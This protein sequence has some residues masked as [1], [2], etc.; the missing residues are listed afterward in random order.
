MQPAKIWLSRY[1]KFV[2]AFTLLLISFGGTVTTKK[3]GLS[4]PDW[5]TS[6]GHNMFT[7]PFHLW[8]GDVFWEHSHRLIGSVM[9]M[10]I[11]GLVIWIMCLERRTWVKNLAWASLVIVIIQGV[12]GGLRVTELSIVLAI[13]HGCT[14]QAFFCLVLLI[15]MAL[16]PEWTRPLASGIA[17]ARVASL[18]SWSWVLVGAIFI[19]LILGAIMRHIDAGLAI[20]TFPLTPEG[21]FMPREHNMHVD[22]HFAHRFWA[23]VVTVLVGILV[24]K[25]L[26]NVASERRFSRPALTLVVLLVVQIALGAAI[27]FTQRA[28]HPTTSHVVNGALVLALGVVIAVRSN[29]FSTLDHD[30]PFSASATPVQA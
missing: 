30:Q 20:P 9:G 14:A 28:S 18:K 17:P 10:L 26:R 2:V 21:T 3:A 1:A 15:A 23:I 12:M 25:V 13:I 6:F 11:I 29:R 24:T 27:I 4:V 5:P 19:Q 16:S 22:I 7:L 8:E